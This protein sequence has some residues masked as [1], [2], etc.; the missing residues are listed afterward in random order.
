MESDSQARRCQALAKLV[1]ESTALLKMI[2]QIPAVAASEAPVLVSG[3]TGTGKEL[4]ARALHYLSPRAE[5]PFVAVNCGSLPE[6]LLEDELFGHERGAFTNADARREGLIEQAEKGTLFLDE[7]DT[8]AGKAQVDLLRVL[9]DRKYRSIG[10]NRE[11]EANVRIVAATNVALDQLLRS[12]VFRSDLYYRLCVFSITLP[13]LRS[14]KEDIPALA[15]HFLKKHAPA[16]RT[17][18]GFSPGATAALLAWDWPGNVRE[19]E[20]AIVRGI[21]LCRHDLIEVSDLGLGPGGAGA[22]PATESALGRDLSFRAMK[23][24]TIE[25]FERDYLARLMSEHRGNVS[26][27]ARASGKERRDLGKL[28][29][30]YQL[31]PKSFRSP[32]A[33]VPPQP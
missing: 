12:G 25:G 10:S 27:A 13:P 8:L 14:R 32:V 3:E 18:L 22:A 30:K 33:E 6:T 23:R 31:D 2:E 9:Q 16:G 21:H 28:L 26:Q 1:G 29:R 20:N 4:V 7:V 11:K 15:A 24:A 17:N 5:T 19:L